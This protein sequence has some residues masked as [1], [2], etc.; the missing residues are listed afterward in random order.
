MSASLAAQTFQA[1][2]SELQSSMSKRRCGLDV[3][4]TTTETAEYNTV[5]VDTSLGTHFAMLVSKS[6]TK[7]V[8]EHMKCFPKIVEI[9]IHSLKVKRRATLYHMPDSMHIWSAFHGVKGSWFLSVDASGIPSFD[10]NQNSSELGLSGCMKM[11][12]RNV[13]TNRGGLS[14]DINGTHTLPLSFPGGVAA[15]YVDLGMIPKKNCM[16]TGSHSKKKRKMRHTQDAFHNSNFDATTEVLRVMNDQCVLNEGSLLPAVVEKSNIGN[17]VNCQNHLGSDK[18]KGGTVLEKISPNM[19]DSEKEFEV[20]QDVRALEIAVNIQD[21]SEV[22]QTLKVA[23]IQPYETHIPEEKHYTLKREVEV[24]SSYKASD[25]SIPDLTRKESPELT[26]RRKKRRK[27]GAKQLASTNIERPGTEQNDN[28]ISG[29][30]RLLCPISGHIPEETDK[31]ESIL[32]PK[33]KDAQFELLDGSTQDTDEKLPSAHENEAYFLTLSQTKQTLEAVDAGK[34]ELN[35]KT[36]NS[37]SNAL[38]DFP[39]SEK[40]KQILESIQVEKDSD[41]KA[42]KKRKKKMHTSS[43]VKENLTVKDQKVGVG[44]SRTEE[45]LMNSVNSE[46]DEIHVASSQVLSC[47]S[48]EKLQ[49]KHEIAVITGDLARTKDDEGEGSNFKQYFVPVRYQDIVGSPDKVEKASQSNMEMKTMKNVAKNGLPS[50]MKESILYPKGVDVQLE[51]LDGS[52]LDADEK[53][54]SAHGNEA[55]FMMLTQAKQT[56]EA[57]ASGKREMDKDNQTFAGNAHADFSVVEKDNHTVESNLVEKDIENTMNKDKKA[58]NKRKKKVLTISDLQ[59][60]LAEK[61]Q[62]AGVG[63]STAD[64]S[65]MSNVNLEMEGIHVTSSQVVSRKS[66][67]KLEEKHGIAVNTDDLARTAEDQGEGINFKQYFVPCQYQDKLCSPGEVKTARQEMKILK[68]LEKN[69]LPSDREEIILCSKGQDVLLL[70][71]STQDGDE[72]VLGAHGNEADSVMSTQTKQTLEAVASRKGEMDKETQ[73]SAVNAHADF[74]VSEKVSQILDSHQ[75]KDSKNT[76]NKDQKAKNKRKKKVLTTS[77][78]QEN[79]TEEQKVCVGVSTAEGNSKSYINSET[80]EIHVASS[81]VV[82]RKSEEKLEEKHEFAINTDDLARKTEDEGEGINFKQYFVACQYQDKVPSPGKI[83]KAS[84]SNMEMKSLKK[85]KRKGLSSVSISTE[86]E[87]SLDLAANQE[88]ES[89][90]LARKDSA[91][92]HGDS[93]TTIQKPMGTPESSL[94]YKKNA[95]FKK[96][97]SQSSEK[98]PEKREIKI[99]QSG[100]NGTNRMEMKTTEKRSL[101]AGAIFDDNSGESSGDENETA[102]LSGSTGSPSDS[103]SMSDYSVGESNLSQD[104]IRN[105]SSDAKERSTG[106]K[107]KSSTPCTGEY[108]TAYDPEKLES[109]QEDKDDDLTG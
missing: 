58:K 75:V 94:P 2:S 15:K 102:H 17:I 49:E 90:S 109:V 96:S 50:N 74:P 59:E 40:E 36:Q 76:V 91:K 6:D 47:K 31:E 104:S 32:Y 73:N 43:N 30:S 80:E 3:N 86:V 13:T 71:G 12:V 51:L 24:P 92:R 69:G 8:L 65:S 93:A 101:L 83:K 89:K 54:L 72:K 98:V 66:E 10:F 42:K 19:M 46:M 62:N 77:D 64:E 16:N 56:L 105:G 28:G 100:L 35:E 22:G 38:G 68:K 79:L 9:R 45:N 107:D 26:G 27:K 84:E 25:Q 44:L 7:M 95:S 34:R 29:C 99:S 1:L 82:S 23:S 106:R 67:E 85:V 88:S 21:T 57:V 20:C 37:A 18:K 61:D 33:G 97:S 103:S 53:L 60:N 41:I 108:D 5:F 14:S 52:T 11:E 70:D 87:S 81:Q 78:V 48:E 39:V 55:D 63:L 4:G